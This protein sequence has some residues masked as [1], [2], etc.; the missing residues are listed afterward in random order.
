MSIMAAVLAV[1]WFAWLRHTDARQ[2]WMRWMKQIT[3]IR[4]QPRP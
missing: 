1:A 4:S 2:W 3:H